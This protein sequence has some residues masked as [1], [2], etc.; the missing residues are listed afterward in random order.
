MILKSKQRVA[1]ANAATE[2]AKIAAGGA[3]TTLESMMAGA[4]AGSATTVISNPIWVIN[5][6]QTVRTEQPSGPG[7]NGQVQKVKKLSF[8]E[9]IS[10][11]RKTDGIKAFWKGLGPALVLVINPILQYTAYEQLRAWVLDGKRKRGAIMRLS[12]L[13]VFLLGALSKLFA[14]GVTYPQIGGC[15]TVRLAGSK[16]TIYLLPCHSDQKPTTERWEG[17]Q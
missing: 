6:R 7:K 17:I 2:G 16:L 1:A 3:L 12:D 8:F 11:V 14:T 13:E 15:E 5:T 4:I 9:T 10:H